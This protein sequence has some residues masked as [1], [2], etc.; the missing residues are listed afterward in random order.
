MQCKL[1]G[2]K[3]WVRQQEDTHRSAGTIPCPNGCDERCPTCGGTREERW[4]CVINPYRKMFHRMDHHDCRPCTNDEFHVTAPPNP[5]DS[6]LPPSDPNDPRWETGHITMDPT[7]TVDEALVEE[8]FAS[9]EFGCPEMCETQ[10][11]WCDR[12][13]AAERLRELGRERTRA[14][15][16]RDSMLVQVKEQQVVDMRDKV[17]LERERRLQAERQRDEAREALEKIATYA[18]DDAKNCYDT[19]EWMSMTARAALEKMNTKG[20]PND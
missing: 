14:I 11:Q 13:R 9:C 12:C 8:L 6:M 15:E 17:V 5:V 3:G 2:D 7:P 20:D 1:C 16:V 19:A 18:V 10:V 4:C